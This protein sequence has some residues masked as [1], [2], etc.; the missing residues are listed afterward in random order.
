MGSIDLS[1]PLTCP[2]FIDRRASETP[3]RVWAVIPKT[4][5]LRDGYRNVTYAQFANG[6]NKV[7]WW[8]DNHLP[9]LGEFDTVFY[10]GPNDVRW[11]FIMFAIQKTKRQLLILNPNNSIEADIK[12]LEQTN[13]Q[14]IV[15]AKGSG[16]HSAELSKAVPTLGYV[17]FPEVEVFLSDEVV[18]MYPYEEPATEEEAARIPWKISHT[19]GTTGED[20]LASL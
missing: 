9:R 14:T 7:A 17:A 2:P 4:E 19:S 10:D 6:I 1:C 5:N 15:A 13:C 16:G 11:L 3:D 8:L 12:L 18:E 20:I